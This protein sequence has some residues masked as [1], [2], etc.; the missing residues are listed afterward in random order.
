MLQADLATAMAQLDARFT[1]LLWLQ[2]AAYTAAT[3]ALMGL[4]LAIAA[5]LWG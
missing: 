1:R 4:G 5:V 3:A 2:L